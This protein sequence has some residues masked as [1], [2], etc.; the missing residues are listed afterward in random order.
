MRV[1]FC[2]TVHNRLHQFA[3]TFD[4]NASRVLADPDAEWIVLNFNS[5]DRLD[6]FMRERLPHLPRRVIY[7]RDRSGAG[8][9][10]LWPRTSHTGLLVERC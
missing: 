6:Q 1:S 8:G 2:T 4:H 3:R 10:L 9:M 7:A 5:S